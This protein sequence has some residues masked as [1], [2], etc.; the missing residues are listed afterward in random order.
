MTSTL[1]TLMM[2]V[3]TSWFT[4]SFEF[5]LSILGVAYLTR[6]LGWRY[7]APALI[8]TG[9]ALSRLALDMAARPL[10]LAQIGT[11]ITV[12]VVGVG[13]LLAVLGDIALWRM[14]T[15][16]PPP[17]GYPPLFAWVI[18]PIFALIPMHEAE[19]VSGFVDSALLVV[20]VIAPMYIIVFQ[21]RRAKRSAKRT[22]T[23]P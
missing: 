7:A 5:A 8:L 17:K 21:V 20:G 3:Q 18:L 2:I 22:H 10:I 15:A 23:A 1:H 11:Q 12:L 6:R 13:L 9:V 14:V 16:A 19:I 4:A